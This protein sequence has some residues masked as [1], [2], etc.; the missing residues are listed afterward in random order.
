MAILVAPH[1]PARAADSH[2]TAQLGG[3]WNLDLKES[4][5]LQQKME[6]MR[7][8]G[9]GWR[10]GGGRWGGAG[11][12]PPLGGGS[13][14]YG[15]RGGHRSEGDGSEEGRGPRNPE[16][17]DLAQPPMSL[18]IEPGDSTFILSERGRT[19]QVLVLGDLAAAASIQPD[20]PHAQAR[21]N[22]DHL[23]TERTG[24]RGG[25]ITQEF[26]LD[27]KGQKLTIHTRVEGRS[28][29]PPL[30]LKR[31]YRRSTG[32]EQAPAAP[33]APSDSAK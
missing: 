23:T 7:R 20:A 4:E 3:L 22:G 30:E 28:G 19:L 1:T 9:G 17:R 12:G 13:G 10:G 29:R 2:P 8:S 31:V 14:G 15:G 11:G 6:E 5:T 27:D 18:M 25:K 33:V 21:W 24:A 26:E 32:E 16:M